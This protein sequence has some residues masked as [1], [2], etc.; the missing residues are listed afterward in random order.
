LYI[1]LARAPNGLLGARIPSLYNELYGERLRLQGRKL[2]DVLMRSKKIIMIGSDG[3]GDKLFQFVEPQQ[4]KFLHETMPVGLP[5]PT[6]L[7]EKDFDLDFKVPGRLLADG[8]SDFGASSSSSRSESVS[9]RSTEHTILP[10][11]HL[12]SGKNVSAEPDRL[13]EQFLFRNSAADLYS[14]EDPGDHLR[15]TLTSLNSGEEIWSNDGVSPFA[16]SRGT[17]YN[18]SRTTSISTEGY[19]DSFSLSVGDMQSDLLR[20][21]LSPT[22]NR[23]AKSVGGKLDSKNG[24]SM[25]NDMRRKSFQGI[26]EN[27]E[28]NSGAVIFNLDKGSESLY[29]DSIDI[30]LRGTMRGPPGF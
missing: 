16:L 7:D 15:T 23:F 26:P 5:V 10:A 24:F 21:S 11:F 13:G 9:G 22:Q 1:L 4:Y 29:S 6:V 30:P 8:F 12:F 27:E 17:S 28:Y 2:K 20:L 18:P 25:F 19:G 3:P 14:A